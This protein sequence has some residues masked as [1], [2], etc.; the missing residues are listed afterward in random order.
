MMKFNKKELSTQKQFDELS[1]YLSEEKIDENPLE[2]TKVILNIA[3]KLRASSR[4]YS[5]NLDFLKKVADFA[6]YHQKEPKILENCV[7]AIGQFGGL[8]KD[9]KCKEFCF[10]YLKK[11]VDSEN[12]KVKF[13]ANSLIICFYAEMLRN[14]PDYFQFAINS[15][16]IAPKQH[17]VEIFS[18]FI[19]IHIDW[20]DKDQLQQAQNVFDNYAKKVKN[21]FEKHLY[22]KIVELLSNH[23]Y[24]G[25]ILKSKELLTVARDFAIK[26][27]YK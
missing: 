24:N 22:Q 9:K 11:F 18:I 6:A 20:F 27:T 26:K 16:N 4:F 5:E 2:T 8:S 12:K 25:K 1:W 21:D 19:S 14:E 17:S 23:I 13:K 15:C 7:N 10:D 3:L